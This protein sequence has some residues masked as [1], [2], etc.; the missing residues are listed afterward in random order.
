MTILMWARHRFSW[1]L[2]HRIGFPIGG[3][4][5]MDRVWSSVFI[6]W[7]IKVLV[8]RFGGAPAYRRSQ[9]F[10]LGMILGEALCSGMWLVIDESRCLSAPARVL[11][12]F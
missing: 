4:F 10:F 9:T 8:L 11:Y 3:N 7:T 1:W 2:I 12:V 5:M 6:A